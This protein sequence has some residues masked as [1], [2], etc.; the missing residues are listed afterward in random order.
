MRVDACLVAQP[1]VDF[2]VFLGLT[3]EA[4]G[5]SPAS[6]SDAARRKMVDAERFISCLQSFTTPEVTPSLPV[7]LL[8][9]ITFSI[10]VA[11]DDRD[12]LDII[13]VAA[14]MP[15]VKAE[16]K[17]RGIQIVV[18]TGTMTQWREA[19]I[20]GTQRGGSIQAC[21]CKIMH[22]FNDMNLNVWGDCDRR[23]SGPMF[24]LEHKA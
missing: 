17:A 13:Q 24:L 19:V 10:L 22:I 23:G 3:H 11:A 2:K 8:G 21:Y 6:A 15:F 18:L 4:L 1:L 20:A 14:G 9:H 7:N 12:M 5:Y 16:T